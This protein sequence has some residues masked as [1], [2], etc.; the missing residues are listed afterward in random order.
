MAGRLRI[1]VKIQLLVGVMAVVAVVIAALGQWAIS[2]Y[3]SRTDAILDASRRAAFG[4]K[5]GSAIYAIVMDSRGVYMAR[6]ADEVRKFAE[7]MAKSLDAFEKMA[8]EW[9]GVVPAEQT[10]EF[11]KLNKELVDFIRF[12]RELIRL[13]LEQGAPA[14]RVFGD[15]D[16]NRS[17][18][19]KLGK[20][21]DEYSA[22]ADREVDEN[23][24]AMDAF[25][26]QLKIGL[27]LGALTALL[28]GGIV[29]LIMVRRSVSGPLGRVAA[30]T[31]RMA[32][33]YLDEPVADAERGDEAGEIARALQVF[34]DT[35]RRTRELEA[36]ALAEQRR[37]AERAEYLERRTA[38]FDR[39]VQSLLGDVGEVVRT[40]STT[41]DNLHRNVDDAG[42]ESASVAVAAAQS[43]A[44]V[45]E[46]A[47]ATG[48]LRS[49]SMGIAERVRETTAIVRETVDV[50]EG[51]GAT[52]ASLDD[53][54]KRIGEVVSLINDIAAQTNLL[55]LNATI[56]AARAGEAGKGFAVVAGEVKNLANQTARATDEIGRQVAAM[57]DTVA[58]VVAT[59]HRV[60]ES[61][62]RIESVAGAVASAAVEQGHVTD[63]IVQNVQEAAQGGRSVTD[64]ISKV[65]RQVEAGGAMAGDLAHMAHSLADRAQSLRA[66]VTGFLV[67]AKTV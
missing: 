14:A 9:R 21:V 4:Q 35:M 18:R 44:N 58:Q 24:L 40:V 46:V 66:A 32:A 65:S 8:A 63:A 56:E 62:G 30:A 41:A 61:I 67:D 31:H 60:A 1:G 36:A 51:A 54:A 19:Q 12:R 64:S 52:M 23:H 3:D 55:A 6:N 25:A 37:R 10:A 13:G 48:Q 20:L 22:M 2:S 57:Q 43:C 33:G 7:P 5:A 53:G 49:S 47:S 29:T 34:R 50:M 27:L 28:G 59:N 45:Q 38:E 42:H 39:T 11:A 15:N 26:G 17:N 16:A